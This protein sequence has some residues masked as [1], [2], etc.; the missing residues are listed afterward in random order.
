M[1]FVRTLKPCCSLEMRSDKYSEGQYL[2]MAISKGQVL[3]FLELTA[4]QLLGGFGRDISFEIFQA[5]KSLPSKKKSKK[6]NEHEQ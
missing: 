3:L 2:A 4:T 5:G 1:A 6:S